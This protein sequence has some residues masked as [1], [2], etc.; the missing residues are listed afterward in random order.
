[1]LLG[2]GVLIAAMSSYFHVH[3]F[4][5]SSTRV[6]GRV[7]RFVDGD[8]ASVHYPI[9]FFRDDSGR[10]HRVYTDVAGR[11]AGNYQLGDKVTLLY[12]PDHER[13]AVRAAF[14]NIWS[15]PVELCGLGVFSLLFGLGVLFVAKSQ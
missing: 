10:F 1:M 3:S 2:A 4:V 9:Y 8:T 13:D 7:M 12:Q 6:D 11:H 5:K 14:W 15:R